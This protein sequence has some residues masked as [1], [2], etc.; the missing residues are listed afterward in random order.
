MKVKL[1]IG[2]ALSIAAVFLLGSAF[3]PTLCRSRETANRVK[4]SSNLRQIGVAIELYA[5]EHAGMLPDSFATLVRSED[6]VPEVF[7][8][9]SSNAERADSIETLATH[10]TKDNC[11]YTYLGD[12][13]KQNEVTDDVV[14]MVE[15][16]D[17]HDRDGINILFGDGH[18]DFVQVNRRT[19]QKWYV[20]LE[21]AMKGTAT[22]RPV[23]L[24]SEK[25]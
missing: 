5:K 17:D 18:V 24:L 12:G 4:C 20:P 10:P 16:L 6:L 1:P 9:P 8:C 25:P 11:S 14:L 2:I 15:D 7:T 13:L 21:A 19:P 3:L 22:T 23:R